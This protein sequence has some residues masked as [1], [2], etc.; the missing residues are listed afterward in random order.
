MLLFELLY[1]DIS[2]LR[3]PN[4]DLNYVKARLQDYAF[5]SYKGASKF[6]EN[7]LPKAKFNALKSLIRNKELIVQKADKDNTVVFFL[8]DKIT[9]LKR[10]RF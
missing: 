2:S 3:I 10:N 9:F 7:N 6:M 4:F 8:T 1:R 5:S